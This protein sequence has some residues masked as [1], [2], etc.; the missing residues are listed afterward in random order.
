MARIQPAIDTPSPTMPHAPV[1]PASASRSSQGSPQKP[2]LER[3]MTMTGLNNRAA[4][5][6]KRM[7]PVGLREM[8]N[9]T[10]ASEWRTKVL[11]GRKTSAVMFEMQKTGWIIGVHAASR[12]M[13]ASLP[14][15]QYC[16]LFL[17]RSRSMRARRPTLIPMAVTMVRASAHPRLTSRVRALSTIDEFH[18]LSATL[19]RWQGLDHGE[20]SRFY[21]SDH[22]GGSVVHGL[23][24]RARLISLG[25]ESPH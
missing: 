18:R 12:R 13:L 5:A 23:C 9:S 3:T 7:N 4:N 2:R 1:S 24:I 8:F 16:R 25:D 14:A 20:R 6:L 11:A 15:V 22:T 19:L 17:T 21:S 10:M